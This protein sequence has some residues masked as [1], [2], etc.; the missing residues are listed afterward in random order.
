MIGSINSASGTSLQTSQ[1]PPLSKDLMAKTTEFEA[2][3]LEQLLD[4]VQKTFTG[5]G[6]SDSDAG[7]DTVNSMGT[8]A[9]AK[10]MA[11]QGGIGLAKMLRQ[12]LTGVTK[13]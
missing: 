8:Q 6:D 3:L 7:G 1:N 2:M 12:Q 11:E 13:K 10:G 5:V 9:L 4:K